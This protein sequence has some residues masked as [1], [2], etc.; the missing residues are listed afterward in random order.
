MERYSSLDEVIERIR[1]AKVEKKPLSIAYEGN[2]VSLW[3]KLV[4]VQDIQVDLG[5]DQTSLHNPYGGGYYPVQLSFQEGNQLLES[6]AAKFKTLVQ[7]SLRRHVTAVNTL[8]SRGMKFWD[9]GNSLYVC[10]LFG[11]TITDAYLAYWKLDA[12]KRMFLSQMED[13]SI[14]RMWK[15]SW[16]TFSLWDLVLLDVRLFCHLL[17]V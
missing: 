4:E 15:T 7:E 16:V 14:L 12:P 17:Y 10:L 5:S 6:D 11:V 13:S 8:A 1:K 2:V 3:E 9:Y